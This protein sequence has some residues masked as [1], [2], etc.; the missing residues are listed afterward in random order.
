MAPAAARSHAGVRREVLTNML[1]S[2]ARRRSSSASTLR[3]QFAS[4]ATAAIGP[5]SSSTLRG[6]GSAPNSG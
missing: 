3:H 6:P 4:S 1:P 5:P 2:A